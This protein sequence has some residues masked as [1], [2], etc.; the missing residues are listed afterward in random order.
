MRFHAVA[1]QLPGLFAAAVLFA[2]PAAAHA[3]DKPGPA[4][5]LSGTDKEAMIGMARQFLVES[6]M[7]NLVRHN[8]H[9][10]PLKRLAKEI[11]H[12]DDL[13][14]A[15]LM[16]LATLKRIDMSLDSDPQQQTLVDRLGAL[17]GDPFDKAYIAEAVRHHSSAILMLLGTI[18]TSPI[19]AE[20]KEIAARMVLPTQQHLIDGAEMAAPSED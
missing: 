3:G 16:T 9:S 12:D 2:A 17:S 19:H 5:S 14:L 18:L 10:E 11:E 13:A 1:T 4:A 15:Q 7:A 20:V 8:S 6:E